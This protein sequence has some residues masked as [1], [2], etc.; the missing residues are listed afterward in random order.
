MSRNN[1]S[2]ARKT[3]KTLFL[4][5]LNKNSKVKNDYL[6]LSIWLTTQKNNNNKILILINFC[7]QSKALPRAYPS[8]PKSKSPDPSASFSAC[9]TGLIACLIFWFVSTWA[10]V[11]AQD[12][13]NSNLQASEQAKWLFLIT[14]KQP[15]Q[16]FNVFVY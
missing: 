11:A 8:P 2:L 9:C 10:G 5:E 1:Y 6:W 4:N 15:L 13:H 7:C 12:K 3:I 16:K 14:V